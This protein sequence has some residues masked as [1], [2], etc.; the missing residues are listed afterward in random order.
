MGVFFSICKNPSTRENERREQRL[1]GRDK[2]DTSVSRKYGANYPSSVK[3]GN[4]SKGLWL[5]IES[6]TRV[7]NVGCEPGS[8]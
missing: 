2:K 5:F 8:R 7:S 4:A 6:K 3:W 1:S